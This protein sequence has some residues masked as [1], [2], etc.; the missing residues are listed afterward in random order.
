M[1][2]LWDYDYTVYWDHDWGCLLPGYQYSYWVMLVLELS[3][4]QK[5]R[6]FKEEGGRKDEE[7]KFGSRRAKD[8]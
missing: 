1:D 4:S 5:I 3:N 8:Q 7:P 6:Y 2:L